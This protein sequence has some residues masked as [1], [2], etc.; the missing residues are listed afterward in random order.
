MKKP[1]GLII[2]A[3]VILWASQSFGV[4]LIQAYNEASPGAGYDRIVY[5]DPDVLYTGGLNIANENVCILSAGSQIDLQG[6]QILVQTSASLD[7]SGAVIT[8]GVNTD[9]ALDYAGAGNGWIDHCTFWGNYN[10]V[11]FWDGSDMVLTSN[12]FSFSSHYG[13]YTHEDAERWMA[14]NDAWSNTSGH[15]KE[16]CP[17]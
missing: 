3:V 1:T 10:S 17:G 15:Y 4:P 7:I 11:Y 9:A 14:F 2:V 16:Y 12:I 8:D 13:V 5:L 6:G